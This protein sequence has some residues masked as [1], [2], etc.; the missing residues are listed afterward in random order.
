MGVAY[1]PASEYID[2]IVTACQKAKSGNWFS[3]H[4]VLSW[5]AN[6]MHLFSVATFRG[7]D[8]IKISLSKGYWRTN[9]IWESQGTCRMGKKQKE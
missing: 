9:N 4:P 1:G 8:V 6:V 5:P 3:L 7:L 2:V